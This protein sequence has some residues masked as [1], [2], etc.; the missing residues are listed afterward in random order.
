MDK[1]SIAECRRLKAISRRGKQWL[2]KKS[3]KALRGVGECYRISATLCQWAI[4]EM[5]TR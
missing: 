5:K 3:K 4:E 1:A 2:P